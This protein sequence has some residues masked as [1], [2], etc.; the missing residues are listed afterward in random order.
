MV[1]DHLGRFTKEGS[2]GHWLRMI[3]L[4]KKA[5]ELKLHDGDLTAW[6]SYIKHWNEA[7]TDRI[8]K[9][10]N[11]YERIKNSDLPEEVK[12]SILLRLK[13]VIDRNVLSKAENS[14][15]HWITLPTLEQNPEPYADRRHILLDE[16][17]RILAGDVPRE[18]Q[19][20]KIN[21]MEAWRRLNEN[22]KK[23][24]NSFTAELDKRDISYNYKEY[25]KSI[26][27]EK[28]GYYVIG[29]DI[30]YAEDKWGRETI[31]Q[32]FLNIYKPFS[33][34][35]VS[36]EVNYHDKDKLQKYN[37]K[38]EAESKVWTIPFSEL[39]NLLEDANKGKFKGV[40]IEDSVVEGYHN[41]EKIKESGEEL[42][43]T[44]DQID[45][46]EIIKDRL[47]NRLEQ[48]KERGFDVSAALENIDKVK[49]AM[50]FIIADREDDYS[51]ILKLKVHAKKDLGD[52]TKEIEGPIIN[53]YEAGKLKIWDKNEQR[54]YIVSPDEIIKI[55]PIGKESTERENEEEKDEELPEEAKKVL[56]EIIDKLG[57]LGIK[58]TRTA[59][60]PVLSERLSHVNASLK[61]KKISIKVGNGVN[62]TGLANA[63]PDEGEVFVI[64][65]DSRGQ[66]GVRVN[67]ADKDKIKKLGG[68]W[69]SFEGY[70]R[71]P[72][73]KLFD[74]FKEFKNGII[75]WSAV[76]QYYERK[77]EEERK[78]EE[79]RR[80]QEYKERTPLPDNQLVNTLRE[81]GFKPELEPPKNEEGEP[82]LV[83][84]KGTFSIVVPS[85]DKSKIMIRG[86]TYELKQQLDKYSKV[87]KVTIDNKSEW[88]RYASPKDFKAI[89]KILKDFRIGPNAQKLINEALETT[90][91][92]FYKS[93]D[94]GKMDIHALLED[95]ISDERE[96]IIFYKKL[97]QMDD[98]SKEDKQVIKNILADERRHY[99][100]LIDLAEGLEKARSK[101]EWEEVK[102]RKKEKYKGIPKNKFADPEHYSYPIDTRKHVLAAWRYINMPKNAR[103]YTPDKL[104]Q[105]K[106]RIKR[107]AKKFGIKINDD[108]D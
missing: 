35:R 54:K 102:E 40:K 57:D 10:I 2:R 8:E 80:I 70:W 68:K 93:K 38:W 19:G 97:L 104:K 94:G 36:V 81:L 64:G 45:K 11:K 85:S 95:A 86:N 47:K 4:Y 25:P 91:K 107:A 90:E 13:H 29:E 82:W 34:H 37:A 92:S 6:M 3:K 66:I 74:I 23:L 22:K 49:Q 46:A 39:M 52:K 43:G 96:G 14:G 61:E 78:E 75:N 103:K 5:K 100:A 24:K 20:H 108:E 7:K 32:G 26:N 30:E 89:A 73:D 50:H 41:W 53:L 87:Q 16:E 76:L 51:N 60:Y 106:N 83:V 72:I 33:K 48:L 27:G 71:L 1:R 55:E 98:L 69:D 101:E 63:M 79:K 67:Y 88:V 21:D 15:E 42:E 9:L 65:A 62:E 105:V 84:G 17:G 77:V 12:A 44:P 31:K 28:R 56:N 59:F 99:K 18:M 58:A